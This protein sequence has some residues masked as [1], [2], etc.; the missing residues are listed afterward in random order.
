[1]A[2]RMAKF[3]PISEC[4]KAF[5]SGD[6]FTDNILLLRSIIKHQENGLSPNTVFVDVMKGFDSVSHKSILIAA[7]RI[8]VPPPFLCYLREICTYSITT[9]CIGRVC[10]EPIQISC[11]GNPMS[12]HLFNAVIDWAL[13]DL[14]PSIGI[15]IVGTKLN[16][17]AI[18][19]D[20]VILSVHQGELRVS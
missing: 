10:S 2:N 19:D 13:S 8:G 12:C 1:M 4:E 7:E 18:A 11:H 20:I 17:L 16:H 5:R 14:D 3:L 9:I 15:D 6:G